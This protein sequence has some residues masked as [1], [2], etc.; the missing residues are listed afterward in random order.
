MRLKLRSWRWR[1]TK[2]E[3]GKWRREGE[4]EGR[5][6]LRRGCWWGFIDGKKEEQRRL[7][8][9]GQGDEH[10][11]LVLFPVRKKKTRQEVG[12]GCKELGQ[13]W[14]WPLRPRQPF[15]FCFLFFFTVYCFLYRNQN[16]MNLESKSFANIFI[17]LYLYLKFDL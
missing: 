3:E 15:F 17:K 9:G 6:G 7:L 8:G 1:E 16:I 4:V 11:Q 14:A 5:L 10:A 2:G 13:S 12:L